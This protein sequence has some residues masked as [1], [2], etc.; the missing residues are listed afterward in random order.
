MICYRDRRKL[1]GP[2]CPEWLAGWTPVAGHGV[3]HRDTERGHVVGVADPLLFSPPPRGWFDIDQDWEAAPLGPINPGV[4][5]RDL[6]W[7]DSRPAQDLAERCWMAPVILTAGGERAYRVAYG[8][9]WLPALTP[10]QDRAEKI[11]RA[12][13]EALAGGGADMAVACQWAA[14]LLCITYHLHVSVIAH[15]A[16]L[17]ERLV[18]EVLGVAAGYDLEVSRGH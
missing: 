2:S 15:L 16:L 10:A 5:A 6:L 1:D 8:P 13:R 14:E 7:C 18:P 4:L 12:A 3:C 9:N 11:A 17:D